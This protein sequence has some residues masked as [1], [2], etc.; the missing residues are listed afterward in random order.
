[1]AVSWYYGR[2]YLP[3]PH[4]TPI[5]VAIGRVIQLPRLEK[6]EK[7]S[8]ELVEKYHRILMDEFSALFERYKG[9]VGWEKK[10]LKIV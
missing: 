5:L 6:G 7:P 2:W 9:A 1:M 8:E 3:I 10:S 4:R